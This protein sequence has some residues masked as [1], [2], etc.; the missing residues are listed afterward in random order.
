MEQCKKSSAVGLVILCI[1]SQNA[2]A[3]WN[4]ECYS[5]NVCYKLLEDGRNFTWSEAYD[6]CR[7]EKGYL[8]N[9]TWIAVSTVFS[10]PSG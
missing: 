10:L 8:L 2:A 6:L 9:E 1:L 7:K 3:E 4:K 5:N